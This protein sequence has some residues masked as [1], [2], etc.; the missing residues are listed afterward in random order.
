MRGGN[1]QEVVPG[2]GGWVPHPP[3]KG[4]AGGRYEGK[5]TASLDSYGSTEFR[6]I[7]A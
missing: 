6:G 3:Q 4:E 1:I 2:K 7:T 5:G